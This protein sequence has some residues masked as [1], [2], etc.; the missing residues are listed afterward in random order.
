MRRTEGLALGGWAQVARATFTRDRRTATSYRTG[1]L[2]TFGGSIAN[3]L[4]I[5]FL[6]KAFGLATPVESYGESYFGFAVV[7]VAFS[8]FMGVGLTGI[9]SR[10][11]EGQLMGT[12]ELMLLSPNRLGVLL[13]SSSLWSHAQA[14]VTL[15]IMLLAA[16]ALGMDLSQANIPMA[17]ASLVLAVVSFSALGLIAASVVIVIKQGNPVSLLLGFA[18]ILLAGVLYPTSVLP[19]WLQAIGQLLPL[20][21]AL[22]LIRGSVLR[23]EGI[24]TLWGPFLSL[25]VLT[26]VL[27]PVGLW[28]CSRAV[29]LAQTDGSLSQY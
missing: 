29:R 28:A 24:E 6:S 10:I 13:F 25:A 8:T 16:A 9:G 3:I 23:G 7:G 14:T 12:L 17:A 26:A 19:G 22:E 11:R 5:Y 15:F 20:T 1:F 4:S 2:L 21:Q 27:L 18:S